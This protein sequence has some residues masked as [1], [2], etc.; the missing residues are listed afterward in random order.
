MIPVADDVALWR[1]RAANAR[2]AAERMRDTRCR[3]MVLRI[4]QSNE[5]MA[6]LAVRRLTRRSGLLR[7]SR[8]R[9]GL[10]G[11]IGGGAGWAMAYM[12]VTTV[13]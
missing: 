9:F 13:H 3:W 10:A 7:A 4:A 11:L 8:L 2:I 6:E 5:R 1:E 12:L